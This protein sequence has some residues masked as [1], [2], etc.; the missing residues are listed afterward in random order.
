[1][2]VHSAGNLFRCGEHWGKIFP[3]KLD[4][5]GRMFLVPWCPSQSLISVVA[6]HCL[7]A[8]RLCKKPDPTPPE[9]L[10]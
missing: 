10:L 5:Y 3:A 4:S 7:V 2:R 6:I 9:S 1:M 8:S